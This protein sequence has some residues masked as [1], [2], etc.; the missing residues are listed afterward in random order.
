[1]AGKRLERT[2]KDISEA[3]RKMRS[4]GILTTSVIADDRGFLEYCASPRI[5]AKKKKLRGVV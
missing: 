4:S 1:M 5:G 3:C 2:K